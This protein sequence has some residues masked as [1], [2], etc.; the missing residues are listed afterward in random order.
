MDGRREEKKTGS[1]MSDKT[2]YIEL[3]ETRL[4]LEKTKTKT[5]IHV[6]TYLFILCAL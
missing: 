1:E 6:Y 4:A 5:Y 3:K 2:V